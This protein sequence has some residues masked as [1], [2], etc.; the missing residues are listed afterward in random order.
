MRVFGL[1]DFFDFSLLELV[2][3]PSPLDSWFYP[4]SGRKPKLP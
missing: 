3:V 2:I 4:Y 1:V